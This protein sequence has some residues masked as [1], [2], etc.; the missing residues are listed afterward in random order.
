MKI[1][2]KV[3]EASFRPVVRIYEEHYRSMPRKRASNAAFALTV[4]MEKY[5]EGQ[6]ELHCVWRFRE[7]FS[8][9]QLIPTLRSL[10]HASWSRVFWNVLE[11]HS[12]HHCHDLQSF[13]RHHC[14]TLRF[15]QKVLKRSYN[16]FHWLRTFQCFSVVYS[17]NTLALYYAQ[18]KSPG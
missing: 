14:F 3:A 10:C 17:L 18:S 2:E 5:R 15:V 13:E 8:D 11:L 12:K 7:N 1:W 16:G 9:G 6:R 4:L